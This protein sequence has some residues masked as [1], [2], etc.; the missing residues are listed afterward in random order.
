M[1]IDLIW[2]TL[3]KSTSKYIVLF[4]NLHYSIKITKLLSEIA[5]VPTCQL[6]ILLNDLSKYFHKNVLEI[7]GIEPGESRLLLP[8]PVIER[9]VIQS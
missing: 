2:Y 9:G 6:C 3:K 7:S 4:N 5:L 8:D 1:V